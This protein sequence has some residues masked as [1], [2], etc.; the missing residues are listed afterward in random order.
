VTSAVCSRHCQLPTRSEYTCA[1]RAC[2]PRCRRCS[3]ALPLAGGQQG[4]RPCCYHSR[5]V[6][7]QSALPLPIHRRA[8]GPVKDRPTGQA[9]HASVK[10][11]MD[12]GQR[13]ATVPL[14]RARQR[15][16]SPRAR[17]S[18]RLHRHF[19]P[20]PP[21]TTTRSPTSVALQHPEP[22][23]SACTYSPCAAAAR[24]AQAGASPGAAGG[25]PKGHTE[26]VRTLDGRLPCASAAHRSRGG[27]VAE[28]LRHAEAGTA[29]G[30]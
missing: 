10:L 7:C 27:R 8:P 16:G 14:P 29:A 19:G 12:H 13:A 9:P 2:G 5:R 15:A 6:Q 3:R 11:A 24:A 20:R 18:L 25:P 1:R 28:Q 17:T 23:L 21:S 30:A 26:R 4:R 22:D